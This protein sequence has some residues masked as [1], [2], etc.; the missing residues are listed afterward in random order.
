M[1]TTVKILSV[2][3]FIDNINQFLT[4]KQVIVKGEIGEK[5]NQYPS[6]IFFTLLD[7]DKSALKCFMWRSILE[8]MSTLLVSGVEVIVEG[9]AEVRKNRGELTFQVKRISFIGEGYLKKKFELLKR[10]LAVQGYFDEERKKS[11]NPFIKRIALITS[12]SARGAFND[13][14]KNL[15]N[16]GFE[17]YFYDVKVEGFSALDEIIKAI[18]WF[19]SSNLMVEVIVII[20]GGGDWE[21]LEPFNTKEIVKAIFSSRIPVVTGIGH[22]DDKT[23]ADYA[24]DVCTST[25]TAA[26]L[27]LRERLDSLI[28]RINFLRVFLINS[29]QEKLRHFRK[30]LYYQQENLS[31]FGISRHQNKLKSHQDFLIY[32][33]AGILKR[34]NDKLEQFSQIINVS[35]PRLQLKRGYSISKDMSGKIIKNSSLLT[36]NQVIKNIFY[37]G[38]ALSTIKKIINDNNEKEKV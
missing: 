38:E 31:K 20:R 32:T 16:Y 15:G 33:F 13:F 18:E 26:A 27:F 25:P 35:N 12:K 34:I 30:A 4:N 29:F 3:E 14:L 36:K 8:E 5:I 7:K 21:S 6:F 37:K 28:E 1:T 2:S 17:I 23:L 19:N 9:Y 10:E 11:I 22:E 24:A